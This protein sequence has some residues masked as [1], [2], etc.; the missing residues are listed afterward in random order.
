MLTRQPPELD[1]DTFGPCFTMKPQLPLSML[2]QAPRW[3]AWHSCPVAQLPSLSGDMQKA[4][5]LWNGTVLTA[6]GRCHR[7]Q[8][9]VFATEC[10]SQGYPISTW[11]GRRHPC[12][13]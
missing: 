11:D 8:L 5:A 2:A 4:A 10:S 13:L 1:Q 12:L 6:L 3:L 9:I 7:L